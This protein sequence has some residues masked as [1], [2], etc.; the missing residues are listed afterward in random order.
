MKVGDLVIYSQ[1]WRNENLLYKDEALEQ[2][3][4]GLIIKKNAD[5]WGRVYYITWSGDSWRTWEHG[6]D[7]EL[8]SEGR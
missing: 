5:I 2:Y 4:V 3:G 8:V 1:D 6:K 7:L